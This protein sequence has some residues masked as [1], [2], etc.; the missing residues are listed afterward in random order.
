MACN[1]EDPAMNP[2]SRLS[3]IIT[4]CIVANGIGWTAGVYASGPAYT[5]YSLDDYLPV[6]SGGFRYTSSP[7]GE[8][9]GILKV[10]EQVK[11]HGIRHKVSTRGMHIPDKAANN[12]VTRYDYTFPTACGGTSFSLYEGGNFTAL[13][14]DQENGSVVLDMLDGGSPYTAPRLWG[15]YDQ[16]LNTNTRMVTVA[17]VN[18]NHGSGLM[19]ASFLAGEVTGMSAAVQK[20]V[21]NDYSSAVYTASRCLQRN[22]EGKLVVTR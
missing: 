3:K 10:A 6:V 20:Q 14:F 21:G 8:L 17:S 18:G 5:V 16:V 22:G 11:M 1:P 15:P 7:Y 2:L 4:V 13:G 19:N 12:I 9:L